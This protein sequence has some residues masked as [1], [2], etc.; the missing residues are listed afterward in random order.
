MPSGPKP[1]SGFDPGIPAAGDFFV[2]ESVLGVTLRIAFADL[3]A[4]IG[5][6]TPGTPGKD[7]SFIFPDDPEDI[8]IIPGERGT[9]GILGTS[10]R[11]GITM[12]LEGES[13]EEPMLILGPKGDT[14]PQG[15]AGSGGGGGSTILLSEETLEDST[16]MF[17]P[18]ELKPQ[19]IFIGAYNPRLSLGVGTTTITTDHYAV[20]T[21]ELRL[22]VGCH[23]V[24]DGDAQLVVI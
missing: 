7:A 2:F 9:A 22:P 14:G 24:L 15:P 4:V 8:M 20:M 6:G 19:D 21:R 10:G 3:Q 5:A 1:I 16:P 17:P 23:M 13:P 18:L 12:F 11:D